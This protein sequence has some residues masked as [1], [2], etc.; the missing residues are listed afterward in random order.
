MVMGW[1]IGTLL[2][3]AAEQRIR[4]MGLRC[5]ELAGEECNPR[6]RALYE[7]LGY[8]AYGRRPEA[9]D[10]ETEDGSVR[11]HQTVCTLIRK[12]LW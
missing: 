11:R 10:E 5:A 4:A 1:G 9:W 8:V 3:E 6:A 2:I 7:R 12:E